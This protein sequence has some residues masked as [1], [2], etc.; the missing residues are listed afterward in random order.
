MSGIPFSFA[1]FVFLSN[2]VSFLIERSLNMSM[3]TL[4][5]AFDLIGTTKSGISP[6]AK[7][8]LLL[9]AEATHDEIP[10]GWLYTTA[11]Q[12][13]AQRAG[14]SL[15]DLYGAINEL[16]SNQIIRK[17]ENGYELMQGAS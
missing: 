7:L 11:I 17:S 5:Y 6:L 1:K 13:L 2:E 10:R 16:E 9:L 14:I 4:V 15:P 12:T 8:V 3:E